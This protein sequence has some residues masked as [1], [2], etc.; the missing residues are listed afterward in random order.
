MCTFSSSY[1]LHVSVN[2]AFV[3]NKN[4]MMTLVYDGDIDK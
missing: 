2:M 4:S 3:K 1:L